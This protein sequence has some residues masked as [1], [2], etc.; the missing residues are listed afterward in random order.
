MID[1]KS[2][3]S[4]RKFWVALIGFI[5]ALMFAF[6]FAEADVE[7][8]AGIITAGST[9]IVYI[10]AE[11]HVDANRDS[12][13]GNTYNTYYPDGFL[14]AIEEEEDEALE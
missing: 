5:S 9:L 2:K 11:A 12:S 13:I 6:N 8:V 10:L 1:W 7:K 4:S 3:L 14:N